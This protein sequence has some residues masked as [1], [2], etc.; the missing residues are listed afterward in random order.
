MIICLLLQICSCAFYETMRL[1]E[2]WL[3]V[4]WM[5]VFLL[6]LF[7]CY[8]QT[9]NSWNKSF[10]NIP[11]WSKN[12]SQPVRIDFV[13][14]AFPRFRIVPII[15]RKWYTDCGVSQLELETVCRTEWKLQNGRRG[16]PGTSFFLEK[17]LLTSAVS[18]WCLTDSCFFQQPQR[19]PS[20]R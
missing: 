4:L 19:R 14:I 5:C 15:S 2:S 1:S 10:S 16:N 8:R 11:K 18:N 6:L 9:N 20:S 7:V 13:R 3:Y 17:Q 12:I